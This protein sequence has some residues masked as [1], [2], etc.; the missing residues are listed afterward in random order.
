M[1]IKIDSSVKN[2]IIGITFP[3]IFIVL[4]AWMILNFSVVVHLFDRVV[5]FLLPFIIGFALAFLMVPLQNQ[6][7]KRFLKNVVISQKI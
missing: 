2:L 1:K 4:F 3:G 6:F 7:E 5:G